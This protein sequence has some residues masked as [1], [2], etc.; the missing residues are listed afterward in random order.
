MRIP[1]LHELGRVYIP[2]ENLI[3]EFSNTKSL[4]YSFHCPSFR[5]HVVD[6]DDV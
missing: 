4:F 2:S 5:S 1:I 3:F 6:N